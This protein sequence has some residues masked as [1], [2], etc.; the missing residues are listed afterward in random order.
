VSRKRTLISSNLSKTQNINDVDID[1]TP[2][3]SKKQK[4][5]V[6]DSDLDTDSEDRR[7]PNARGPYV[8]HAPISERKANN[9]PWQR[10][11]IV[12]K[13]PVQFSGP[14][15]GVNDESEM[16]EAALW[17]FVALTVLVEIHDKPAIRD[18][19][20]LDWILFTPIFG[21]IITR[22]RY[23]FL[24]SIIHCSKRLF[25]FYI[26]E[27]G[28]PDDA[29]WKVR[30]LFDMFNTNWA[31]AYN[32]EMHVPPILSNLFGQIEAC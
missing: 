3:A 22:N 7:H 24:S 10:T 1:R 16:T 17:H 13:Q 25:I 30:T 9:I 26:S 19:W 18:N 4:K 21:T 2:K 29:F 28:R 20:S 27:I 32:L 14:C 8:A 11:P 6:V 5:S 12:M 15:P 23:I 31:S